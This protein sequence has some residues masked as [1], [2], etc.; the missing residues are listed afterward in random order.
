M[1]HAPKVWSARRARWS[2]NVYPPFLFNRIVVR[3][4]AEDFTELDMTVERS[5]L[6]RNLQ[7]TTF[8]GSIYAAADPIYAV[9][10]W[11]VMARDGLFVHAWTKSAQVRF[12]KPARTRLALEFRLASADLERARTDLAE[13]GRHEA[14]FVIEPRDRDGSPC[15][16]VE[17]LVHLRKQDA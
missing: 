15:A 14:T 9:M 5:L 17:T 1:S 13:G 2:L 6:T 3:R 4:V 10:L 8:G 12:L 11:Q 7:G 16:R